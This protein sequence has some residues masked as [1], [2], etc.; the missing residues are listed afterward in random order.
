MSTSSTFLG[1][2]S[3]SRHHY[4]KPHNLEHTFSEAG[5]ANTCELLEEFGYHYLGDMNEP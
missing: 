3:N 1:E 5:K 4:E 2:H